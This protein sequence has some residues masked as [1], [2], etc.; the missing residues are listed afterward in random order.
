MIRAVLFDLDRTLVDRDNAILRLFQSQ[1]LRVRAEVSPDQTEAAFVARLLALDNKGIS[2]KT[3]MYERIVEEFMLPPGLARELEHEF[4]ENYARSVATFPDTLATLSSLRRN[5][6]VLGIITNGTS[7]VQQAKIDGTG[8]QAFMSAVLIS[9]TEGIKKPHLEIFQRALQRL[10]VA[11][12]EAVFVGDNLVADVQGAKSAG[13]E[14]VWYADQPGAACAE[15]DGVI[16]TLGELEGWLDDQAKSDRIPPPPGLLVAHDPAWAGE[17]IA[18]RDLYC[19]ALGDLVLRVEHVG[20][21][22]V[23]GLIAKPILDIDLVIAHRAALAAT[24]V[25]LSA[26]GYTHRGDQGIAGREV[27]KRADDH[28]PFTQPPRRWL[29]HHLYVC[30]ADCRELRR[31]LAFRDALLRSPLLCDRYAAIKSELARQ[32]GGDRKRYALLKENACRELVESAISG[33]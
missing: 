8:L 1:W 6:Y 5:G 32:S 4:R 27:F 20:S 24:S 18:L 30:C 3:E 19:A 17:F 2:N 25:A 14:A 9:E 7:R 13:M 31:H 28:T 12:D 33:L 16:N 29:A 23:P 11:P 26:L 15:A 22:A 21:T 10:G